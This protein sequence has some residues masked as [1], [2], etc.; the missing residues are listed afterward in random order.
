MS[1]GFGFVTS[2]FCSV[3][4]VVGFQNCQKKVGFTQ[5]TN[6]Q[7]YDNPDINYFK[8]ALAVRNTSCIFCHASI[9][10]NVITDFAVEEGAHAK[11]VHTVSGSLGTGEYTMG[12]DFGW[13][14]ANGLTTNFIQGTIYMPRRL[15]DSRTLDSIS[16]PLNSAAQI[17]MLL[18][19]NFPQV[20]SLQ[21]SYIYRSDIPLRPVS[22]ADYANA[23]L[24]Y[25]T[26]EYLNFIKNDPGL[27]KNPAVSPVAFIREILDAKITAPTAD[28]LRE[29]FQSPASGLRFE[30]TPGGYDLSGF[31]N[32]DGYYGNDSGWLECDGDLFVDGIVYLKDLKVRTKSGCRIYSTKTIFVYVTEASTS[33]RPG[34]IYDTTISTQGNL[35][36]MSSKAIIMGLGKCTSGDSL[37]NRSHDERTD[38]TPT[39]VGVGAIADY[40]QLIS[41]GLQLYD[42]GNCQNYANLGR[43]VNFE[44]LIMNAPIVHTRYTGDIKGVLI[45]QHMV[46]SLGK[47]AYEYDPVFDTAAI[48]PVIPSEQYFTVRDCATYNKS[49]R[50]MVHDDSRPVGQESRYRTCH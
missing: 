21:G 26:T 50:Q 15:I 31:S 9:V 12:G 43:S 35:G 23:V 10:G 11:F 20:P 6:L 40:N 44:H 34:I 25:R 2:I 3:I 38:N 22:I 41:S 46:G 7:S 48:F 49:T 16:G 37:I 24:N 19:P 8:P 27:P 17:P 28:Q 29:N 47:F 14:A 18:L 39:L 33:H 30:R 32:K 13:R 5:V 45:A 1:R 4:L 36:L 42:A